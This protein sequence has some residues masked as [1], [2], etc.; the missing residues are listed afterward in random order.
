MNIGY[1]AALV[2]GLLWALD[3]IFLSFIQASSI[4]VSLFHDG[5]SF[6][7]IL[8][9][10]I[11]SKS[12]KDIFRISKKSFIIIAIASF[13]GGFVGM[14]SFIASIHYSG[15][16]VAVLFSSLYPIISIIL[17]KFLLKDMLSR[18]GLFGILLA[19]FAGICLCFV[20]Y[21]DYEFS[22]MGILFGSLCAIGWGFECVI[23]NIAL[24]DDVPAK[25]AL[26]IRQSV[27]F[28]CFF[29][30]IIIITLFYNSTFF[31]DNMSID[32]IFDKIIFASLFGT[33]SYGLYYIGI[34]KI[35]ALKAMGLNISYSFWAVL[36]SYFFGA[37]MILIK[38]VLAVTLI[39]GS[40]LSNL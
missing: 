13:F 4:L 15:I 12:F 1:I 22:A 40:L 33:L 19:V 7:F 38:L 17:S 29:I 27:S 14:G 20:S 18:I 26:F 30:C 36:L 35:G 28:S 9:F 39:I 5:L 31:E 23:I 6:I 8:L 37:K 11:I 2:S 3:G 32:F 10:L 21:N 34:K 16:G 25:F 24:K